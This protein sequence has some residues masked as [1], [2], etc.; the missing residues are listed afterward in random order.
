MRL[1]N[2]AN[3]ST[4]EERQNAREERRVSMGRL[5]VSQTEEQREKTRGMNRLGIRYR[6]AQLRDQLQN[7]LRRDA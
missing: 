6:R 3:Q 5:R 4:E 7:N 1:R 2:I